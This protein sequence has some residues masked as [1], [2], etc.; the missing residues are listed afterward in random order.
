M[1]TTVQPWKNVAPNR[2]DAT[3]MERAIRTLDRQA[4]IQNDQVIADINTVIT[5]IANITNGTTT[6]SAKWVAYSGP[7][8]LIWFLWSVA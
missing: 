3:G 2:K 1:A 7:G 5:N 8:W 4:Q 6:V